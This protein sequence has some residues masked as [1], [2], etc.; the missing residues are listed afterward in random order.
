MTDQKPLALQIEEAF[1]KALMNVH[2]SLSNITVIQDNAVLQTFSDGEFANIVTR[3]EESQEELT[4][5]IL[6]DLLDLDQQSLYLRHA[7]DNR[8]ILHNDK[9]NLNVSLQ[10]VPND[11]IYLLTEPYIDIERFESSTTNAI[12]YLDESIW[13]ISEFGEDEL[14]DFLPVQDRDLDDITFDNLKLVDLNK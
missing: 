3:F 9:I 6:I 1:S 4:Y 2:S 12:I 8:M 13:D 10:F 5:D 7:C 14:F 11:G